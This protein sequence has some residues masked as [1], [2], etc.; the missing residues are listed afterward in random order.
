MDKKGADINFKNLIVEAEDKLSQLNWLISK[1]KRIEK[2][3]LSFFE[4]STKPLHDHLEKCKRENLDPTKIPFD[5]SNT[6]TQN[7]LERELKRSFKSQMF[8]EAFYYF[9]WRLLVILKNLD[10]L[11]NIECEGILIVRNKLIEH[12]E[13]KDSKITIRSFASGGSNGPVIKGVRYSHQKDTYKDKGLYINAKELRVKL[14]KALKNL[15]DNKQGQ[16]R[17]V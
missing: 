7:E 1:I 3:S 4:K 15:L 16:A 13:R 6:P 8:S 12:S 5:N 2:K 9:A 14:E 11:K 10:G 17:S